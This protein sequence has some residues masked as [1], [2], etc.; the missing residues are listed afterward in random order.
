MPEPTAS[1]APLAA[2]PEDTKVKSSPRAWS[3]AAL[4]HRAF[5][6]PINYTRYQ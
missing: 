6:Q 4:M 1:A 3:W 2:G 5:D